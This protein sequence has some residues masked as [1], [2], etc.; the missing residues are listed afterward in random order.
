M[1]L[2]SMYW[3]DRRQSNIVEMGT[4]F[5]IVV[6]L[7]QS[8]IFYGKSMSRRK[9][10]SYW[11][12]VIVDKNLDIINKLSEMEKNRINM[13]SCFQWIIFFI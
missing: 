6:Q 4:L 8:T 12:C 13:F 2:F 3:N 5:D 7:Q 10:K 9:E 1:Q 11:F